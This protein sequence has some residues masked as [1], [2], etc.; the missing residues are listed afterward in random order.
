MFT[1]DFGTDTENGSWR[2][3]KNIEIEHL[4]SGPN[5][6]EET[7]ATKLRWLGQVERM[8]KGHRNVRS[9]YRWTDEAQK[10][11]KYLDISGWTKQAQNWEEWQKLMSKA[12]THFGS[13]RHRS[14]QV[15]IIF[16]FFNI[17]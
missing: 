1:E 9:R 2:A 10:D 16:T 8:D 3:W 17:F 6:V 5:I 14:K 7:K 4:M 15:S 13:L 11:Q 12:K